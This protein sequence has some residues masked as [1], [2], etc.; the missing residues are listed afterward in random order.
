MAMQALEL[1]RKRAI[2]VREALLARHPAIA[3]DRVEA[4]GK[5]WDEPVGSDGDLNRRVEVRWYT[6]E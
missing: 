6:I 1:S 2:A 3:P 4:I 5:G